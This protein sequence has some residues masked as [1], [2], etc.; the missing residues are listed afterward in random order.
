MSSELE[1][2]I[3]AHGPGPEAKPAASLLTLPLELRH[4]I[5]SHVLKWERIIPLLSPY[6]FGFRW[7]DRIRPEHLHLFYVCK[8]LHTEATTYFLGENIFLLDLDEQHLRLLSSGR[9]SES[10]LRHMTQMN[11]NIADAVGNG[12]WGSYLTFRK[13][14]VTEL[15]MGQNVW[16]LN[17]EKGDNEALVL[18]TPVTSNDPNSKARHVARNAVAFTGEFH[19]RMSDKQGVDVKFLRDLV[20]KVKGAMHRTITG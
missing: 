13:P 18:M 15:R 4:Q 6:S 19:A 1:S 12:V 11:L 2:K 9:I 8:Q 7:A 16:R 17:A 10:Y 3:V 20:A 5:F 14:G